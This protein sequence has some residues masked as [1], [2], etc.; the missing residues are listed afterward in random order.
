MKI[1]KNLL[2][3]FWSTPK[4]SKLPTGQG[5]L[6][7]I[8]YLLVIGFFVF[9]AFSNLAFR[10]QENSL[11]KTAEPFKD[12][13]LEAKA[14]Y[15]FDVLKDRPLFELNAEAQ[16]PLASLTK[17]MTAFVAKEKIPS[18]LFVTINKEAVMQEGDS[19]FSVGEQWSVPDLID[20]M[21]I[22]SSNDAAFGLASEFEKYF[23]GNFIFLM[24]EKAKELN[25]NQ[26]YFLNATGLD[27][28]ENVSGGYGSA[29][30]IAKLLLYVIK[31]DSSLIETTRLNSL[32]L[33]SREFKNTDEI[34]NEVPGFIAGKTGYSD[35]AGG[36]LAVVADKGY[37]HP[38]IIV[39]LGSTLEGRFNDVKTLYNLIP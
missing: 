11:S 33:H 22:S 31:N 34:V 26:T 6:R 24:N 37:G 21:L 35:L 32:T 16:L 19:G 14:A 12:V 29:K 18:Y 9:L 15:V 28:S 27:L 10:P 1:L 3:N 4:E 2:D 13:R 17:I 8:P 20:A 7:A 36:N 5:L 23:G 38:V 25:L 30:D 39:V